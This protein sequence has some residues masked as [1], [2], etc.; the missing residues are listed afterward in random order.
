RVPASSTLPQPAEIGRL[1]EVLQTLREIERDEAAGRLLPLRAATPEVLDQ[2]RRLLAALDLAAALVREL[3]DSAHEWVFGLRE[4][5]R[6]A[7][8]ATERGSL[9][10]LFS[11]MDALLQARAEFMQRPVTAPREALEHPR[12]LEAIA[13]GA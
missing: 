12:A 13:R 2:A 7:D 3:E 10:A 4:K 11:E 9:E 1:H 6:R 8:F 5:L